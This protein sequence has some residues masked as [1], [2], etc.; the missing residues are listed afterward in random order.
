MS[1][2]VAVVQTKLT[3][4]QTRFAEAYVETGNASA[5]YRV[6]YDADRMRPST[7][8]RNAFDLLNNNKIAARV[9]ELQAASAKRNEITVD[10]LTEAL[11][12]DRDVA[13]L[14]GHSSAAIR[15][16]EVLMKLHG[17]GVSKQQISHSSFAHLSDE[18]LQAE[19][20]RLM[21]KLREAEVLN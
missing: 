12:H 8:N 10:R 20:D 5:A 4:K 16:V 17:L 14:R 21:A 6:A 19:H 11:L 3:P 15:A 13:L 9:A 7:I 2:E 18:E 1:S